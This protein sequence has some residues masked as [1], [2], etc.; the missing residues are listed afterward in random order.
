VPGA[1]GRRKILG[2]HTETMPL[3]DD[4]D[5]DRIA[6]RTEGFTG[7]DLENLVR[8]AGLQAIRESG[9]DVKEVP[10]RLFEKALEES[11]PSVTPEIEQEYRRLAEKLKQ[12]SPLE[13]R[14]GFALPA[15]RDGAG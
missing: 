10:M 9:A 3:G 1:E 8:R 7:A 13:R 14:I 11:R 2:I 5:L 12:E 4:V 6:K 15:E